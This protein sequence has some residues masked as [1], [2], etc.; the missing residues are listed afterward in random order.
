MKRVFLVIAAIFILILLSGCLYDT[1]LNKDLRVPAK[2]GKVTQVMIQD[3]DAYFSVWT[4]KN[5]ALEYLYDGK[6][7]LLVVTRILSRSN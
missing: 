3:S 7:H 1:E 6:W 4:D 5:Y 2:Y